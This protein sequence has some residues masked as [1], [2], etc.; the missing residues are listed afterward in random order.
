M[1]MSVDEIR[2]FYKNNGKDMFEYAG[3]LN[4]YKNAQKYYAHKLETILKEVCGVDTTL[5]SDKLKTLFLVVMHNID[6]DS[7]WPIMNNPYAKY[8]DLE[9]NGERSNLH[10]SLWQLLRASTAAP[11]YFLPEEINV[12]ERIFSFVD[13]AITP[14]NN[15]AFQAYLMSTLKAYNINWHKGEENLLLVS[16]GTGEAEMNGIEDSILDS[17]G[18][19][20]KAKSVPKHLL[21]S[22][23]YQQDMLCRI[24]GNCLVGDVL[25]AEIGDLKDANGS[26]CTNENLF[27]Y[28]RYDVK[29]SRESFKALSLEHINPKDVSELDAVEAIDAMAEV[30]RVVAERK[31]RVEDFEGF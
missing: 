26:G 27:T 31:V 15:P 19:V 24:F 20:Q 21:N 7:A 3:K 1:G 16:I 12:G 5:Q 30:G 23:A 29:L 22:I 11:T 25:D 10:L 13:G 8:N 28:L 17:L 18:I 14:Y 4:E 6:T 9:K 2:S